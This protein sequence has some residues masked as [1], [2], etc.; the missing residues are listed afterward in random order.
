MYF[1]KQGKQVD[2]YEFDDRIGGMSAHFDFN[3]MDIERYYHYVC[4]QDH[5][6]FDLMDEL[7]IRDKLQWVDTKMGYF[8]ND[9][10]HTW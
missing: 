9:Q 1:T 7:N 8:F 3:G 10:L 5:P 4:G 6:L 2:V